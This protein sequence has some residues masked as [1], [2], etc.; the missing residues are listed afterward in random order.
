[1]VFKYNLPF[2]QLGSNISATVSQWSLSIWKDF[3][4]SIISISLLILL[5]NSRDAK[6]TALY[7]ALL[8]IT[9]NLHLSYMNASSADII[10]SLK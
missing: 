2:F 9:F 5:S 7:F 8:I 6:I 4:N 1:M 3:C 10:H